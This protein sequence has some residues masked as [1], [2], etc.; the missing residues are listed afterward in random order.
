MDAVH[1]VSSDFASWKQSLRCSTYH[2]WFKC[3]PECEDRARKEQREQRERQR[4]L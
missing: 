4:E 1:H 3:H 2:A